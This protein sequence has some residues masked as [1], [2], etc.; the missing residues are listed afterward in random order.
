[1]ARYAQP[2]TM[3]I[4]NTAHVVRFYEYLKKRQEKGDPIEVYQFNITGRII[5][6]YKWVEKKLGDKTIMAPGSKLM[7]VNGIPRP[8]DGTQ[9]TIEETELFLLQT[10]R[11][12]VKYKPHPVWGGKVLVPVE[13]P[14]ISQERLKQL[15]P[16]SYVSMEGFKALLKAQIEESKYW[17]DK[18]CPGLPKEM[19]HAM[20]FDD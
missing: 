9:P 12:A 19:Y 3:G 16:T 15:D 17:L 2:F 13:M 14:G 18:N 11:G 7:E 20:D 8:V 5:A 6:K 4:P 10:V 1:M